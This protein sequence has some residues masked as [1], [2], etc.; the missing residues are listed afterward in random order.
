[1]NIENLI[2]DYY[3]PDT[4]LYA[5][6]MDHARCVTRK[7]LEVA[8]RVKDLNPDIRFIEEAAMLHDIGIFMTNSPSIHCTGDHPYICHGF[9]GREL[10]EQLGPDFFRHALVCERHTGAGITSEN[11]KTNAL[12]LP[13]RDMV[14]LTLEEEIICFADKFYSKKPEL[15][16]IEKRVNQVVEEMF[17]LDKSHGERFLGWV[18]KFSEPDPLQSCT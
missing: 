10:L 16:G 8:A 4:L 5:L 14:P 2:R 17:D 7:S 1:M 13:C 6:F 9:L 18:K 3:K 12:P 15:A 11:I